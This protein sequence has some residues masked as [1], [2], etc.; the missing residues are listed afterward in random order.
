MSQDLGKYNVDEL[1]NLISTLENEETPLT[2]PKAKKVSKE[3]PVEQPVETIQEK[4]ERQK[5]GWTPAKQEAFKKVQEARRKQVEEIRN[6]KKLESAKVLLSELEIKERN[7][8]VKPQLKREKK[9][10]QLEVEQEQEP[11]EPSDSSSSEEEE[12][13]IKKKSSVKKTKNV[14]K[15]KKKKTIIIQSESDNDSVDDNEEE[16]EEEIKPKASQRTFKSA[17]NKKSVIK[18]HGEKTFNPD[19]FFV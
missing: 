8:E 19:N 14:D 3:Q 12:I 10:R 11:N 7:E 13:I 15:K 17:R 1:K 9:Q 6:K 2:K 18:V 5:K 4:P 16:E